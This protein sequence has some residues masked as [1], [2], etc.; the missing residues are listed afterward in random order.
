MKKPPS[1]FS[2]SFLNNIPPPA[3]RGKKKIQTLS[4]MHVEHFKKPCGI[5]EVL[6][7]VVHLK[8]ISDLNE[9]SGHS[10]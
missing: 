2:S 9:S 7:V 4:P 1:S 5:I 6:V 3:K 10:I 8:R